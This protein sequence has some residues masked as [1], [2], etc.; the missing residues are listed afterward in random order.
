MRL[1]TQ[2]LIEL[3][4]GGKIGDVFTDAQLKACCER[5]TAP[6]GDGYGYLMSAI[7]YVEREHGIVWKRVTGAGQIQCLGPAEVATVADSVRKS[8]YR[9]SKRAVRQ[10]GAVYDRADNE[11][12]SELNRQ[13]AV[14]GNIL[15]MAS[16]QMQK[17]LKEKDTISTPH[18]PDLG[19]LLEAMV[20]ANGQKRRG[21]MGLDRTRHDS[22]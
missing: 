22:T 12:R 11:T 6:G 17:R 2:L 4:K 14:Q 3:L 16:P 18:K 7:R 10:I 9:R 15:T 19:R 13:M 21:M 5:N 1:A 8:T 20:K